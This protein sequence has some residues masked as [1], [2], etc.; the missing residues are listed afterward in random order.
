MKHI[1][2]VVSTLCFQIDELKAE[3]SEERQRYNNL[4]KQ[5]DVL[6]EKYINEKYEFSD[7]RGNNLIGVILK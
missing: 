4:A 3:L 6:Q 7:N 2:L 1:D 5:F